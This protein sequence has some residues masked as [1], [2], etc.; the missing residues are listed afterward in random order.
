MG[1]ATDLISNYCRYILCVCKYN[2]ALGAAIVLA[3]GLNAGNI[4]HLPQFAI[5]ST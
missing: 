5:R 4:E 3:R 2:V 1:A